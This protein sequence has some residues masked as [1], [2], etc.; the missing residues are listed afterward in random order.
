LS[1]VEG[2]LEAID[3]GFED[4][5][6]AEI[7]GGGNEFVEEGLPERA[8]WLDFGLVVSNC[9]F[10]PAAWRQSEDLAGHLER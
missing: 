2:A 1:A 4:A 9:L 10:W 8:A 6:A 3:S 5:D 7:A